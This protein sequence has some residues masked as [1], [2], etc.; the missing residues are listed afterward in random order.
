[1]PVCTCNIL[2]L[3]STPWRSKIFSCDREE[4]VQWKIAHV[5]S[6]SILHKRFLANNL[7]AMELGLQNNR[8]F[9]LFAVF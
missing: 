6:I 5:Q 2:E 9:Q 7:A 8:F 4:S 1:M 3:I